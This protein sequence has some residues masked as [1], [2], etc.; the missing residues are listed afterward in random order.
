M[1]NNITEMLNGN[2]VEWRNWASS[3]LQEISVSSY[4]CRDCHTE[5]RRRQTVW[6]WC[7][8]IDGACTGDWLG[9]AVA[10]GK[11]S[12]VYTSANPSA[13]SNSSLWI[14]PRTFAFAKGAGADGGE[15]DSEAIMPLT[16]SRMA[17][18]VRA[19]GSK[20]R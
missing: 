14:R 18:C 2:K 10:N 6:S 4:E 20:E 11:G 12:G 16:R 13:Y 17:R 5:L 9:G 3:V 7:G 19:V 8:R 1:V 15:P